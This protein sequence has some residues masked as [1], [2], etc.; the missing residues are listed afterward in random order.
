MSHRAREAAA[1]PTPSGRGR[2]CLIL[3]LVVAA[4][5]YAADQLTKLWVVAELPVGQ[6]FPVIPGLLWWQ[7]IRNSG[8]AFSLGSDFTWVFTVVMAAVVVFI[9]A[10]LR[11]VRHPV[12]AVG[13]GLVL[14]G[15]CGNL[16][17][18]LLREPGLGQ[19]H[20]VDFIAV[21]NFAIFNLADCGVVVGIA[22]IM[23]LILGDRDM[24]RPANP[25][26]AGAADQDSSESQTERPAPDHD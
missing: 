24:T 5:I 16:T 18:R 19:G 20:V 7:H 12:W 25:R 11:K 14:G 10:T 26:P 8:A 22:V 2:R 17:D 13:L 6:Q 1:A 9:A 21:P 23:V 3:S 4:L 15:A